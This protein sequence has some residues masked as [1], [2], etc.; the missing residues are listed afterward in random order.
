MDKM[1]RQATEWEKIF[2]NDMTEKWLIPKIYK[3]FIQLNIKNT[4]NPIKKWS[5]DL[6]IH[7][8]TEDIQ[9][10]NRYVKRCSTPLIIKK[11]QIRTTMRFH[12]IGVRMDSTKKTR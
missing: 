9:L 7:F 2:A 5:E 4:N 12:L 1:K 11:M 6:N 8:S 3:Q 10:A